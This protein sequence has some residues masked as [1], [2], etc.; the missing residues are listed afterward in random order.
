MIFTLKNINTGHS[1]PCKLNLTF[2]AVRDDF[3]LAQNLLK[4]SRSE[5]GDKNEDRFH[6]FNRNTKK[7]DSR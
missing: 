7:K 3:V 1:I 5:G 6:S 2:F 4:S